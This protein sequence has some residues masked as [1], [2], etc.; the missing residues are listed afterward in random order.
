MMVS[1]QFEDEQGSRPRFYRRGMM[2][3][4]PL[5]DLAAARDARV[6]PT[7]PSKRRK[8]PRDFS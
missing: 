7:R 1:D 3:R 2:A 6:M 4:T 8:F 5:D